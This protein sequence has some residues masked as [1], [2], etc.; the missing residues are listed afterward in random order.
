[1]QDRL[2]NDAARQARDDDYAAARAS[3][4]AHIAVEFL[5]TEREVE[6]FMV[7][8]GSSEA[9]TR[10]MCR[11]ARVSE[12]S[13]G[14]V[15]DIVCRADFS[16]AAMG[17]PDAHDYNHVDVSLGPSRLEKMRAGY[18][19]REQMIV[20]GDAVV[21]VNERKPDDAKT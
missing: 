5:C 2:D 21:Y 15:A 19:V 13:L 10:S 8:T 9:T 11:L 1:M 12:M 14:A 4:A 3:I 17:V 16:F 20:F 18:S 6:D 7:R